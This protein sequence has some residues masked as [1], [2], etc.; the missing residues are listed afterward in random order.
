MKIV[1][2]DLTA[3]TLQVPDLPVPQTHQTSPQDFLPSDACR[4]R[5]CDCRIQIRQHRQSF[6]D[7]AGVH[8]ACGEA[9]PARSTRL[10][11]Q[12]NLPSS[13]TS[14]ATRN[15]IIRQLLGG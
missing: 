6:K 7:L 14:F 13:S 8:S 9:R 11:R 15:S 2:A 10:Q 4:S 5:T 12:I 3:P 1:A